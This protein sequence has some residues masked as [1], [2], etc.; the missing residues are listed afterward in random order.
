MKLSIRLILLD[1]ELWQ[2]VR[3][4]SHALLNFKYLSYIEN[5]VSEMR[6]F[7]VYVVGS[8]TCVSGILFIS[9]TKGNVE[10]LKLT[11]GK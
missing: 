8:R 7:N 3:R 5:A 9:F 2:G 4:Y 10:I 1:L 6:K 11:F